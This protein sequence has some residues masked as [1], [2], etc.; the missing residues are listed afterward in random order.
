[1]KRGV[2]VRNSDD[3]FGRLE[4]RVAIWQSAQPHNIAELQ[5]VKNVLGIG[6]INLKKNSAGT[7]ST[8]ILVV[9]CADVSLTAVA[10]NERDTLRASYSYIGG[11]WSLARIYNGAVNIELGDPEA[12]K[13][14]AKIRRVDH[15]QATPDDF[16]RL[17]AV[18]SFFFET[19][20]SIMPA[21]PEL[22]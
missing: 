14:I 7:K 21:Q 2:G 20:N 19:L 22:S 9:K 3:V 15:Y 17:R 8:G 4:E 16:D 18:G 5:F 11:G 13:K 6:V 10:E 12:D 1:M